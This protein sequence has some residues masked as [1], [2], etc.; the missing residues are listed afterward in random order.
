[1]LTE[2]PRFTRLFCYK[3]ENCSFHIRYDCGVPCHL[4]SSFH[5]TSRRLR[6]SWATSAYKQPSL[7]SDP[8][9]WLYLNLSLYLRS[10]SKYNASPTWLC[11]SLRYWAFPPWRDYVN[12]FKTFLLHV[13]NIVKLT[14][15]VPQILKMWYVITTAMLITKY[16][17]RKQMSK[18]SRL[19]R[20]TIL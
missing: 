19:H 8:A 15:T 16:V 9:L 5:W 17:N 4:R 12:I 7:D 11:V 14:D 3:Y 2:V 6:D 20:K 1:M 10:A 18:H 13:T